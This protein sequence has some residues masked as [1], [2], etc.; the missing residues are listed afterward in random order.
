MIRRTVDGTSN[1]ILGCRVRVCIRCKRI[2][3]NFSIPLRWCPHIRRGTNC[4]RGHNR[5][6]ICGEVEKWAKI[7]R[8]A[9]I[10]I[11]LNHRMVFDTHNTIS[12]FASK[13]HCCLT[14]RFCCCS[15]C[16]GSLMCYP[17]TLFQ[18]SMLWTMLPVLLVSALI[19]GEINRE[20]KNSKLRNFLKIFHTF[21]SNCCC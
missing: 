11:T 16:F 14:W 9:D 20:L 13:C 3:L 1:T 8:R 17:L 12:L 6:R 7:F 18:R 4:C 2:R 19:C 15:F 10:R 21:A 5:H